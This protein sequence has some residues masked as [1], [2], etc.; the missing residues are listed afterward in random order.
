MAIILVIDDELAMRELLYDLFTRKGHRVMTGSSAAE[1][2]ETLK[3]QRPQCVVLDAT[4]MEGSGVGAAIAIRAVDAAMPIVWLQRSDDPLRLPEELVHDEHV[5]IVHKELEIE[6][7][8]AAMHAAVDHA[9]HP[10]PVKV[11]TARP[12]DLTV[13]GTVLVADD[14]PKIQQLLKTFFESRGLRVIVAGSGE[15]ALSAMAKKPVAVLLDVN[16]PGMDGLMAL[17]RIKAQAPKVPVIIASGMNDDTIV[18]Q[19]LTNGA[20]DYVTKPF[21]LEYLE[22]VVLTKLLLGMNS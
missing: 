21:N 22:T 18:R 13:A 14:E 4:V 5:E 16:M 10:L 1:A 9:L 3:A 6:R 17:K 11:K 20:Y 2:L 15:E 12:A 7:F 19:A 8:L